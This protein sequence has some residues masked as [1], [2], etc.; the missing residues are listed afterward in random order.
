[1]Y[2]NLIYIMIKK[3]I[4]K[5]L[6]FILGSLILII[7]P[8]IIKFKKNSIYVVNYHA[9]Y[10]DQNENFIKQILFFKKYFKF[11][12]ENFLL[13]KIKDND[14][15][16][17]LLLTF[18][19][20]HIS[21]FEILKILEK[22]NVPA[23][24][25]IPYKFVNRKRK[26]NTLLENKITNKNFNIISDLKKDLEN[27]YK[28]LSMNFTQLN[29]I[30]KKQFSIGAHGYSHIRLSENLTSKQLNKEIIVS[31][32]LLEKKLNRKINSFCWTFGDKISYSKKA[33]NLIKNNYKLSFMTCCK[34]FNFKQ[35][36]LQIHRFNIEN[37]F[38]LPEVAFIL[39]GIYEMIYY[40]KRNYV[41]K[42]TK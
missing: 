37:F 34:P 41:N 16:P 30:D 31:K 39:S 33:S 12:N 20:G 36:L 11:I 18:D 32:K 35:S 29:K 6:F 27:R 9:T 42:L 21:N 10:P 7:F 3:L 4:K 40:K 19:D 28:T 15:K 2:K 25:F 17:K 5:I 8:L 24:F 14:K 26:K 13:K 1:M 38:S 22:Y 23:I